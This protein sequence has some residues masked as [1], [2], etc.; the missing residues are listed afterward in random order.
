VRIDNAIR[1]VV[2]AE[3]A[4]P[5]ITK[6]QKATREMETGFVKTMLQT[7]R[8]STQ[9]SPLGQQYGG[10]VFKDMFDDALAG[11]VTGRVGLGIAQEV[12]RRSGPEVIRQEVE[13][14]AREARNQAPTFSISTPERGR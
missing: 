8:A 5:E 10:K 3:R 9:E 2:A 14:M 4:R 13:E 7:M 6:L 1:T 11:A 12:M